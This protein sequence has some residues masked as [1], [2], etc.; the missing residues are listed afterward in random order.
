MR[1]LVFVSCAHARAGTATTAR[2]QVYCKHVWD[3]AEA[4]YAFAFF[5]SNASVY[6]LLVRPC[7]GQEKHRA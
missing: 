4:W 1:S 6:A 2:S 7:K 3:A 5:E